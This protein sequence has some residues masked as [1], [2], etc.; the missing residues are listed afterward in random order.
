[1]LLVKN[2]GTQVCSYC[3]SGYGFH[4]LFYVFDVCALF[5]AVECSLF[6]LSGQ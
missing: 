1:M 6:I 4:V 2:L 5:I 3:G